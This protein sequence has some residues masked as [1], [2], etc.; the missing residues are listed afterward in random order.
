ME[1]LAASLVLVF[2]LGATS[3]ALL[4]HR[5]GLRLAGPGSPRPASAR[6]FDAAIGTRAQSLR[7]LYDQDE[8]EHDEVERDIWGDEISPRE[9]SPSDE[10]VI[11]WARNVPDE[12]DLWGDA[13]DAA[14]LTDAEA[15]RRVLPVD[16]DVDI[17]ADDAI[18]M[19]A[20]SDLS[21]STDASSRR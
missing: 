4:A 5:G 2:A 10:V 9:T 17:W 18:S 15:E 3:W 7:G 21:R 14:R 19:S 11:E 13:D 12:H 8:A 20:Q 1:L 16:D 6:S